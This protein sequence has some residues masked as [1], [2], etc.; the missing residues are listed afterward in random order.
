MAANRKRKPSPV[1]H[2]CRNSHA[3]CHRARAF[4]TLLLAHSRWVGRAKVIKYA[5]PNKTKSGEAHMRAK[6]MPATVAACG[7]LIAAPAF[8]QGVKIGI[9]NDQ[10]GVY[11]DYGGQYSFE[12]A[13]M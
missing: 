4:A 13:K 3:R 7:L 12:G 2:D 11:A 10:S 1:K 5:A 8:A 6:L 9:L